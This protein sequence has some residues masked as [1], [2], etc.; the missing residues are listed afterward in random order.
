MIYPWGL[1]SYHRSYCFDELRT[2]FSTVRAL[3]CK[4]HITIGSGIYSNLVRVSAREYSC[5]CSESI[6]TRTSIGPMNRGMLKQDSTPMQ[7]EGTL[8]LILRVY[9]TF[10]VCRNIIIT[11]LETYPEMNCPSD[12]VQ[13]HRVLHGSWI[14]KDPERADFSVLHGFVRTLARLGQLI[15]TRSAGFH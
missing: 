14:S 10:S 12:V 13:I 6:S 1:G 7:Q 3:S 8:H 5:H 2:D 9:T 11:I 4:H 15:P